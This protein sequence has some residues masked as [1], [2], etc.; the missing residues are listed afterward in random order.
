MCSRPTGASTAVSS[1]AITDPSTSGNTGRRGVP[2]WEIGAGASMAVRRSALIDVGGFDE[3]LDAGAAGCSGDSE[4]WYR[5]LAAGRVCRYE[6]A[7]VSYHWHRQE[8]PELERQIFHYMRGH[9]TALLIQ[10]EHH[11]HW[12]NL[13]RLL[14]SLPAYYA[15]KSVRHVLGSDRRRTQTLAHEIRGWLAG[16]RYYLAQPR[17]TPPV[18]AATDAQPGPAP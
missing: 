9:A 16:I 14:C 17:Q 18:V 11:H 4:M 8:M 5:I 13:R 2:A 7:A 3:R 1:H 10:F 6:P 12:G 15:G